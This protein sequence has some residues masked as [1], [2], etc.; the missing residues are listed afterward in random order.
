MKQDKTRKDFYLSEDYDAYRAEFAIR[1]F[2][3]ED[4][5]LNLKSTA[6]LLDLIENLQSAAYSAGRA[7][8]EFDAAENEV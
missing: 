1:A 6:K 4:L 8:A 3:K 5:D 7:N 2:I